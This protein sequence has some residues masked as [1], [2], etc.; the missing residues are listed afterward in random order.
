MSR[1]RLVFYWVALVPVGLLML[2]A[3]LLGEVFFA[4]RHD[5]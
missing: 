5:K 3:L 4:G 2:A 1:A